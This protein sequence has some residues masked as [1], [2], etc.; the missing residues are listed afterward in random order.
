MAAQLRERTKTHRTAHFKTVNFILCELYVNKA[1]IKKNPKR[2]AVAT[3]R[4]GSE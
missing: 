4:V 1:V 2:E 3:T